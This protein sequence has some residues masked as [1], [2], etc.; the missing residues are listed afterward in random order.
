MYASA[1]EEIAAL[2]KQLAL[3]AA[4]YSN[5]LTQEQLPNTRST[6]HRHHR[7]RQVKKFKYCWYH[8]KHGADFL[9]DYDLLVDLKCKRLRDGITDLLTPGNSHTSAKTNIKA[10]DSNSAYMEL[11][12]EFADGTRPGATQRQTKI[13]S[14]VHHIQTSPG[15]P[16][17]CKARRLAPDKLKN[18]QAEFRKMIEE[19]ICRPSNSARA[20]PR[21]LAQKKSGEGR[22]CGDY[23]PLNDRTLIDKYSFRYLNDF[24]AFLHGKNI[25]SVVDFAK[26]FLQ[27]PVAPEDVPKTAI[28]TPFGLF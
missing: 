18:A 8:Y 2:H 9:S 13:H 15:P 16:V 20:L 3:L 19:G 27:I 10:V 17:S 24:A 4:E 1:A 28:I 26:A 14:T 7:P 23:R 21:H 12:R 25:F 5:M 22:P 11:L 6:S